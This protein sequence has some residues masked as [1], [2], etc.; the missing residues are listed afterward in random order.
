MVNVTMDQQGTA[1]VNVTFITMVLIAASVAIVT[2]RE[3][4]ATTGQRAM[5]NAHVPYI[6]MVLRAASVAIV[7]SREALAETGQRAMDIATV[8][9]HI[10]LAVDVGL[11]FWAFF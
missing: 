11:Q 8:T 5:E 7:T 9:L 1:H 2:P 4:L 10:R 6:T 3:A